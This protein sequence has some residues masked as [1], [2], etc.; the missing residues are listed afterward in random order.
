MFRVVFGSRSI[1]ERMR[2][3]PFAETLPT[4]P[5]PSTE[6]APTKLRLLR[7]W[8]RNLS[9]PDTEP[10][11][12]ACPEREERGVPKLRGPNNCA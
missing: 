11:S 2:P 4:N 7:F 10:T 12:D 3:A 9:P 8:R 6:S 1:E 5:V